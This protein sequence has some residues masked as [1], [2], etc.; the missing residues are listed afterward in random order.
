MCKII[1]KFRQFAFLFAMAYFVLPFL[2]QNSNAKDL[3]VSPSG[4]DSVSYSSNGINTPWAT[5]AKAW[6]S[7]QSGDVVYFRGGTYNISSTISTNVP[8]GYD[9][10]EESPITFQ[11]YPGETV[12]FVGT[13]GSGPMFQISKNW[14]IVKNININAGNYFNRV[15]AVGWYNG[16]K[17]VTGFVADGLNINN[18]ANGDNTNAFYI[19]SS[20]YAVTATKI[21]IKN[22][23]LTGRSDATHQNYSAIQVFGATEFDIAN[24]DISQANR[25]IYIKHSSAGYSDHNDKIRNNYVHDMN[26]SSYSL[27]VN[28]NYIDITN[29]VIVG[30][31]QFGED[32]ESGSNPNGMYLYFSHNT[33]VGSFE[34]LDDGGGMYVTMVNNLF[35]GNVYI[36]R[37]SANPENPQIKDTN[38]NLYLTGSP[39]THHGVT[40]SLSTWRT[41]LASEGTGGL[42]DIN[43]L[44]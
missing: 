7:A 28:G 39:L 34:Q 23:T 19:G 32:A 5:P 43:S 12:N 13:G 40:Y 2:P 21:T 33:F 41:H 15:F 20:Y 9:G 17:A 14:N 31:T 1:F 16:D 35:N 22:C 24:N 29:N 30:T 37:Y 38:Y 4:Q 42:R 8:N 18:W 26:A 6:Y 3:Y 36:F 44:S 27:R 11:A 10:T 25:G